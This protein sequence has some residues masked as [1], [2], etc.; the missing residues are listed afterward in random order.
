MTATHTTRIE[1]DLLGKLEIS[2]DDYFG[3]QTQRAINNFPLT[4]KKLC[5]YPELIRALSFVKL[6]CAKSNHSLE[7]LSTHKL[8]MIEDAANKVAA[9]EF[10]SAFPID[11]IQ[12]GAGTS[13]N[14]NANEVIA[15]VA[16]EANGFNKG[17]YH[18]LHPNTDVNMSQSTND[19]YPSAIRLAILIKQQ[20]LLVNLEAIIGSLK[21][22][23][24]S[25]SHILKLAR[26]Q[27]QDAVPM[28]LGQE[29]K[30]FAST[31]NE[32]LKLI[33][34]NSQLLTEINLGGTAVGTGINTKK[35]YAQLSVENLAK[36]TG[37]PFT[38]AEDLIEASSDMGAFVIYSSSLKRLAI[39]L[40]KI[41]NDMR[42]L[43]MGPRAGLSE[44]HLPARQ[45][46]SSI[47]PGKVN[48]VIPEA[49]SQSAYQV[50]GYDAAITMAA[51]AGQLQLNAMEPLIAVNILDAIDLL[52]NALDMFDRL[53]IQGI[54]ANEDRCKDLLD[55]SLGLVTALNPYLGY[56]ISTQIAQQ[57]LMSNRSVIDLIKEQELLSDEQIADILR[58]ENMTQ[59]N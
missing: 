16:L 43:S 19:V 25:F 56:D 8:K 14:M 39:K 51:E 20:K 11:M 42:L 26:T 54:E 47:M 48:P 4:K 53:C 2:Q 15:N 7:L 31:L 59:P 1:K 24:E 29:F 32:D 45:P 36:I 12:G 34:A 10:D 46:G 52:T 30:G 13:S 9:G 33:K 18:Q 37:F 28:T 40:S 55:N 23:A 58:P 22:K 44:I 50:I 27:L 5:Q 41:A 6:A 21:A 57:A 3:I 49:V 38:L 35:G 17:D